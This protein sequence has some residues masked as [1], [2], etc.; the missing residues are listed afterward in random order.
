MAEDKAIEEGKVIAILSYIS[1]LCI[2]P[3]ILKKDNKFVLH[4]AKQGL[5]LFIAEV[6]L[7]IL[8]IIPVLGWVVAPIGS[9]VLL[10]VSLIGIIQVL[11]GSYWK[12][13]VVSD[14]A[15]KIKL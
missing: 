2:I 10:I 9:V 15:E 1:I 4:H 11:Q 8:I 12:C 7:S 3:L 13:P 6:A 14:L 5:V